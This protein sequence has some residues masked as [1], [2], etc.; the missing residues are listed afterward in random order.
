MGCAAVTNKQKVAEGQAWT[1]EL[2]LLQDPEECELYRLGG[3][4]GGWFTYVTV[5]MYVFRGMAGGR[6]RQRHGFKLH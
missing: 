5:V 2:T 4:S 6:R 3:C 1:C